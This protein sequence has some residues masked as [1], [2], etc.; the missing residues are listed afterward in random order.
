MEFVVLLLVVHDE[1]FGRH[2]MLCR[3]AGVA[4]TLEL[5]SVSGRIAL[6]FLQYIRAGSNRGILA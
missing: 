5:S 2:T 1:L 6:G 3:W 4:I